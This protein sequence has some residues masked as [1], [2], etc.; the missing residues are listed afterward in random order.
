[1]LESVVLEEWFP[2]ESQ[3]AYR[4]WLDSRAHSAFTG[5]EAVIDDR[6]GGEFTAWDGY[7]LGRTLALDPP[8]QIV[9]AWRTTEFPGSAGDSRLELTFAPSAGGTHL[10][11]RHTEIPEGQ[12]ISYA[13]GWIEHYFEPMQAYFGKRR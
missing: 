10:T 4:A 1:M 12:G 8:R 3:V 13:Q 6:V 2:V 7:I 9:Q 11:L 5:G